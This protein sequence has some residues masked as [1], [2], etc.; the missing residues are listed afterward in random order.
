MNPG[1]T[2][3]IAVEAD[4]EGFSARLDAFNAARAKDSP[5]V[6]IGDAA[7]RAAAGALS[8]HRFFTWAYDDGLR[9]FPAEKIDI[10][11]PVPGGRFTVVRDADKKGTLEIAS[12]L[13]AARAHPESC[14]AYADMTDVIRDR[15]RSLARFAGGMGAGLRAASMFWPRLDMRLHERHRGIFGTF[16]MH[17]MSGLGVSDFASP[18]FSPSIVEMGVCSP[19]SRVVMSDGAPVERRFIRLIGRLDHRLTDVAQTARF[20]QD[21]GKRLG[22]IVV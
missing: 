6:R 9:L 3:V 16:A 22:E 13:A 21:V 14:P 1:P 15:H 4:V 10:R 17:D 5:E 20:L 19:Y 18:V 12:E 2:V 8:V 11:V 7:V